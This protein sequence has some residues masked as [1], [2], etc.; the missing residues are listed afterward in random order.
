MSS[1]SLHRDVQ[2]HGATRAAL[3][4]LSQGGRGEGGDSSKQFDELY[5]TL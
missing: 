2:Q 4:I 3:I 1:S 5:F